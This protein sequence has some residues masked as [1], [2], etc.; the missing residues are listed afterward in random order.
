M[1]VS[2]LVV[3]IVVLALAV[4][5][6]FDGLPAIGAAVGIVLAVTGYTRAKQIGFGVAFA[7]FGGVACGLALLVGLIGPFWL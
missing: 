2:S 1:A 7:V 5:G 6:L 4:A 3:G